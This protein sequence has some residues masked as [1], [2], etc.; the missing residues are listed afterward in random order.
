VSLRSL[1]DRLKSTY[2][3]SDDR[4]NGFFV[5]VLSEASRYDRV[6]GYFRSSALCSV[7]RGLSRLL[8]AGGSMRLIA[9]AEL[10]EDDLRAIED[11]EPLSDVLVRQLLTDP[12]QG[13]TIIE[14]HRLEVLAWMVRERRLQI[15]IGV[16]TD[17]LGR[18]LRRDQTDRYF[19]SKYGIVGDTEGSR[20]AFGG[21]NNESEA[22]LAEHHET[23]S[24]F[25]SWKRE[26]WEWSGQP[27]LDS[28][29][30]HWSGH[31]ELGWKIV[32]LPEA[33]EQQLVSR[34][35]GGSAP[36]P[37]DP[38]EGPSMDQHS[39]EELLRF[40]A[41]A[42]GLHGGTGVGFATAGVTPLPHQ[43]AIAQ[44]IVAS[45]PRSY[46]L[47]DEAGLG[48][49][50]EAGLVIRELLVSGRASRILI[51][52]P[53]SVIRQWQE[54]LD[55]K[56]A[57]RVPRLDGG[58]FFLRRGGIDEEVVPAEP[59]ANPWTAFP[60]LL[61]SSHLA[62]RRA[63]RRAVLDAGPWDVVF[64]DEAHH[65]GRR[66]SKATDTPN[67]LLSLLL[68]MK[69]NRSWTAL[70][71]ASATPMQMHAHEV[72][73]L[74]VL[75]GL[76]RLWGD[77]AET[78]K[79]YYDEL[80]E[81]FGARH[82]DFLQR[83]AADFFSDPEIEPDPQLVE[84]VKERL[85]LAN[86]RP[87]RSFA[88]EGLSAD[89]LDYIDAD[90]RACF[91]VW[92]RR[93]TPVREQVFR[94]TRRTLRTYKQAGILPPETVIPVR[95]VLDRFIPMSDAERSLYDRIED[96]IS[97][98]YDAYLSGPGSQ[99]PLGFIMTVYRRRLTSSFLAIERSL[100][101]R[102][103]VLLGN[104]SAEG[105]LDS[106]DIAAIEFSRLFDTAELPAI[107]KELAEEIGELDSFLA[108]LA[109]RPPDESKM[110]YL[111]NELEDA[112]R[113]QHDTAIIF[114]QYTDTM[115]YIREQ[116]RT[117][118]G[119]RIACWSGRGGERW[120]SES[121][122]W[123]QVP[124]VEVKQLFREGQEVKLL[125]GTDAMSE[126]LNLQTTGLLFNYDMPWNFM[127]VEQRIGRVDRIGGQ[128][129]VDVRNYFY[130]GTVE[131]Q[132]YAGIREDYDWFTDIVGPAQP[133]LGQIEGA[134]EQVAMAGPG[135]T[136]DAQVQR[137]I[138]EIRESIESAKARA[139]TL[140]DVGAEADPA[141]AHPTPAIDLTG[142]E[143]VLTICEATAR[144]FRAHPKI[145]GAYL[146]ETANGA[147]EMTFRRDVLD[148]YAPEVGLLTYSTKELDELLAEAGIPASE[149]DGGRDG[150]P[151]ATLAELEERLSRLPT[152]S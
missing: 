15:R 51:L 109:Q 58:R 57:L 92:L 81:P 128:P 30:A 136:R 152:P 112:F 134:I 56:L 70:Y 151:P 69:A 55:E 132:I 52:V 5:P 116:L 59:S 46:L 23:F 107:G 49:T 78:F 129:V 99:K 60:V 140:D 37:R 138:A 39:Q 137:T 33:V 7:A 139:L 97:R 133:V 101:R 145:R 75:L 22:G 3:D 47:A 115:D 93:H 127:R 126:G 80:R 36:G 54:E 8:A 149:W 90:A 34:A 42:P 135:V 148:E 95:H 43:A 87:I 118:Y 144:R 26:V 50:I 6:T 91:D 76:T 65:A 85:G 14:H 150:E 4:L 124:K 105:L 142:L 20:I 141:A 68:E 121:G 25:P 86:S 31:P 11:G 9:G 123:V 17:R 113:G 110:Q 146:L 45:Y 10:G 2:S 104:A 77:S 28:F 103:Q 94:T 21:S 143:R 29:E 106:D 130:S 48:E 12:L 61:A 114:T 89:S 53:A 66:G 111:H 40:V 74:L 16:P 67:S 82:W 83:M 72:W 71:M 35:K 96:Y 122:A 27:L 38:G 88:T 98:Y 100:Q 73:D 19:H 84:E 119:T 79:R 18:P 102:R 63:H 62:R 44:R 131:E 120:D 41:A 13:A 64:V 1:Q 125:I 32:E 24:V 147:V 108:A 117:F